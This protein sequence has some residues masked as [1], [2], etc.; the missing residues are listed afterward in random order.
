MPEAIE[1]N[2]VRI[3]NSYPNR[4]NIEDNLEGLY[5]YYST[6]TIR[7]KVLKDRFLFY[8]SW[9]AYISFSFAEGR[10]SEKERQNEAE[11]LWKDALLGRRGGGGSLF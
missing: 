2:Y 5:N 11:T 10:G 3:R 4:V 1:R 9:I 7:Y 8:C 6:P